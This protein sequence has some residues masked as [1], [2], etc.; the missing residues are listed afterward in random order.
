MG[1]GSSLAKMSI[2]FDRQLIVLQLCCWKFLDNETL[3]QTFNAF[4]QNSCKKRQTWVSELHFA[5]ITTEARPWLM[6]C[7]KAHGR[8]Y[9]HLNWTFFA[10]C[11]GS[12]VMTRNVYSSAVFAGGWPL[13]SQILSGEGHP[14]STILGI[15]KLETL[16]YPTV[17]TASVCIPSFSHNIGVWC[18]DRRTDLP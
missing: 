9:I 1:T 8:L 10:V 13:C 2:P 5:E 17:K 3:Q 18:T 7:W 4:C 11:Y 14:P 6:A 16:G 12:G 15:R